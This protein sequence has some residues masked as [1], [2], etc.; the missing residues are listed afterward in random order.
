MSLIVG[1]SVTK[2]E[3]ERHLAQHYELG[4]LHS[5]SKMKKGLGNALYRIRTTTGDYTFK[6][7]IR[8]NPV[9]VGYEIELLRHVK[10]LP[11]PQPVRAKDGTYLRDFK[12]YKSFLYP[13]LPGIERKR[14]TD[15]MLRGVGT[16]L[17]KLHLQTRGFSSKIPRIEYYDMPSKNLTKIL[18]DASKEKHPVLAEAI[19]YAGVQLLSYELPKNLPRGAMHID[20]KP[21]N[22]LFRNGRLSGVVDFDNSYTGPLLLDLANTLMWWCSHNGRF[23]FRKARIIYKAYTK[24]R[25]LSGAER[26]AFFTVFHYNI[27]S[28]FIV[29]PYVHHSKDFPTLRIPQDYMLW[30]V[31]HL[32]ATQRNLHISKE[33]FAT[34]F[35]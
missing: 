31:K 6:I 3:L 34:L 35:V 10:H 13:F 20:L 19:A 21:E 29:N 17:G 23:D 25:P 30:E 27:L 7:A 9:R 5:Y 8:N 15:T 26:A 12:G 28:H 14:F 18:K 24:E 2:Q 4:K 33:K 32:L 1:P 16:F 22:A 11:I